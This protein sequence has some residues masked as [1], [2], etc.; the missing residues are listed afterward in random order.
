MQKFV[1][2]FKAGTRAKQAQSRAKM[3]G[4]M[5]LPDVKQSSRAFPNFVFTFDRPSGKTVLRVKSLGKEFKN[6]KLF[7]NLNVEIARGEKVAII[8]ENGIGK[9]TLMKILM[10]KIEQTEGEYEWGHET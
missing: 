10:G 7:S 5:E 3:I 6:K 1:D 2:R 4:K 8:G 9:S